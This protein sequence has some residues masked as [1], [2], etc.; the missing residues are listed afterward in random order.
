M[1]GYCSC[2]GDV[3]WSLSIKL[4]FLICEMKNPHALSDKKLLQ[5]KSKANRSMC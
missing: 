1:V 5:N 4:S 3:K 2:H